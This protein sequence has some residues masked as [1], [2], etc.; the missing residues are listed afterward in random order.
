MVDTS[1]YSTIVRSIKLGIDTVSKII[2]LDSV[3]FRVLV[4]PEKPFHVSV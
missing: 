2:P 1:Y 4:F 3:E